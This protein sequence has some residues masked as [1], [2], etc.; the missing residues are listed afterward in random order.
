MPMSASRAVMR[1]DWSSRARS[2]SWVGSMRY[3]QTSSGPRVRNGSRSKPLTRPC[4]TAQ[5]TATDNVAL[6][7]PMRARIA[8][9]RVSLIG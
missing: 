8:A 2:A 6:P 5:M 4:H 1:V 3:R 9:R 7:M